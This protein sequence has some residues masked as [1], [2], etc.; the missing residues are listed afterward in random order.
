M[1]NPRRN[2]TAAFKAKGRVAG[3]QGSKPL[4]DLGCAGVQMSYRPVSGA[5]RLPAEF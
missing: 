4:A 2:D 1:R 3:A 5:A